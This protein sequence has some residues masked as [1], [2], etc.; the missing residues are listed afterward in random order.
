[1]GKNFFLKAFVR[2]KSLS[3]NCAI[4][5]HVWYC[6]SALFSFFLPKPQNKLNYALFPSP[7]IEPR[8]LE[9]TMGLDYE[10]CLTEKPGRLPIGININLW[11]RSEITLSVV[12][13][14]P[15]IGT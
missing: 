4:L 9:G 3:K 2:D 5:V 7:K 1:M 13:L 15:V 11:S 12:T 14:A 6:S 8:R 10:N